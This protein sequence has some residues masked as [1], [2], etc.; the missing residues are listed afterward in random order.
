MQFL[1]Q[2]L[3]SLSM[4]SNVSLKTNVLI[5]MKFL[6]FQQADLKILFFLVPL[7]GMDILV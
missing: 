1:V 7:G 2:Q 6:F 3:K 5:G 4:L